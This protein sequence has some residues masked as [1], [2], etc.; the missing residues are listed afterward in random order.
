MLE[1]QFSYKFWKKKN[2]NHFIY[3]AQIEPPGRV[4]ENKNSTKFESSYK[5]FFYMFFY[6]TLATSN[7]R[8]LS[9]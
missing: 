4:Y 5:T 9:L 2:A 3:N 8:I 7:P 6:S 1:L